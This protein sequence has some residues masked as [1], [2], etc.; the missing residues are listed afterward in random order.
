MVFAPS[1][2]RGTASLLGRALVNAH[3]HGKFA[4]S[5][6]RGNFDVELAINGL[7]EERREEL[8]AALSANISDGKRLPPI[9][10]GKVRLR[11][12]IDGFS[13]AVAS[14]FA[15]ANFDKML[16]DAGFSSEE[17][18]RCNFEIKL[19]AVDRPAA[20]VKSKVL[21]RKLNEFYYGL[22]VSGAEVFDIAIRQDHGDRTYEV[23]GELTGL[24]ENASALASTRLHEMG[25]FDKVPVVKETLYLKVITDKVG[26]GYGALLLTVSK[27]ARVL[28]IAPANSTLHLHARSALPDED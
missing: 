13:L 24:D 10:D 16:R 22:N 23:N 27:L 1:K 2:L 26:S 7:A 17:Q 9:G 6:E 19:I 14:A 8:V 28:E 21:Q 4:S 11:G 3:K 12:S 18:V 5:G 25:V 20:A 15:I